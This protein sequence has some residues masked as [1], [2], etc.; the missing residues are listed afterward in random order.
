MLEQNRTIVKTVH[1]TKGLFTTE[2]NW[3]SKHQTIQTAVYH[4]TT[5]MN[6]KT[7]HTVTQNKQKKDKLESKD[8]SSFISM[9]VPDS[10]SQ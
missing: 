2:W 1:Q 10:S 4:K 5:E 7:K 8:N 6:K 9:L 3:S